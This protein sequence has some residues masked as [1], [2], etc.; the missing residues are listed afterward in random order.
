MRMTMKHQTGLADAVAGSA[1][2]FA[3]YLIL[4]VFSKARLLLAGAPAG[5]SG[6]CILHRASYDTYGA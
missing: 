5:A 3:L 4:L 6:R 2:L 1:M